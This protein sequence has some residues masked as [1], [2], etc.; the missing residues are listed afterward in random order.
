MANLLNHYFQS[1][2]R[3]CMHEAVNLE[4]LDTPIHKINIVTEGIINL[5]KKLQ[6][7]KAPGPD[8]ITK[9]QLTPDVNTTADILASIFQYS[10]DIG[11]LPSQ[12]KLA[13]IAPIFKSGDKSLPS[14]YRPVSLTSIPCKILE[15]IVLHEM[16][17]VLDSILVYNQ[18]GFRKGLSCATQL[19]TTIHAIAK[20]V[21]SRQC[22]QT[23]L[24]DFSKAFDK[25]SHNQLLGK[26]SQ[27]NIPP[28]I[29]KWIASFLSDRAQRVLLDGD[30]SAVLPVKSGVPQ[31]SVLGPSLFLLYINDLVEVIKFCEIKLFADDILI[32]AEL[33]DIQSVSNF[34]ADLNALQ[35]WADDWTMKF[36]VSKCAMMF[37]GNLPLTGVAPYR[38]KNGVLQVVDQSKYL[39]VTIHESLKWD[40]HIEQTV[41]KASR[42]LGLIK[43]T[44]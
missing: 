27:N 10:V 33:K 38:L 7:G 39:G 23:A 22:I 6:Y 40:R 8:G 3:T 17:E 9:S 37:F 19:V 29:V 24:L 34:Q 41:A 14:N 16:N 18:H 36:N 28:N 31:G 42:I 21:D 30:Q 25:V 26:L 5:I 1:V 35:R 2:F 32:Y 4:E 11:S 20:S 43:R 12:W 44:L 13:N 15:H